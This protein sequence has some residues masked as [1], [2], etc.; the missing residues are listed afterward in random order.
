ML[1]LL[2]L[3]LKSRKNNKNRNKKNYLENL[4]FCI[5]YVFRSQIEIKDLRFSTIKKNDV[6]FYK[7]LEEK[8]FTLKENLKDEAKILLFMIEKHRKFQKDYD[9]KVEKLSNKRHTL[10]EIIQNVFK[11]RHFLGEKLKFE[12]NFFRQT[13]DE[14]VD[15]QKEAEVPKQKRNYLN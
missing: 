15:L 14:F 2:V 6:E 8:G 11:K 4:N 3:L 10:K 12:L 1:L 5:N 13:L 7:A 9:E